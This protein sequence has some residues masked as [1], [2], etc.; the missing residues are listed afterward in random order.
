MEKGKKT[1]VTCGCDV[2]PP[3]SETKETKKTHGP[4]ER[5]R[6]K[7][8]I[9]KPE[10]SQL[11]KTVTPEPVLRLSYDPVD[12]VRSRRQNI[13]LPLKCLDPGRTQLSTVEAKKIISILDETLLRVELI[14][15]FSYVIQNLEEFC[16]IFGPELT[17]ALKEHLRL[18]IFLEAVVSR[19]EKSGLLQKGMARGGIFG[20]ED[21]AGHLPL[22][23][24]GLRGS[25]RNILRLF[26]ANPRAC[27]VVREIAH[28]K[29]ASAPYFMKT[30]L[31]FRAFLFEK[32]LTTPLEEN[33]KSQFLHEMDEQD[34]HNRELIVILE[35]EVSAAIQNR[36]EELSKKDVIVKE[37][38]TQL[39]NLAK[40]SESQI[41][42]TRTEA[43]EQQKEALHSS[44]AKCSKFQQEL[45]QLRAQ[46]SAVIAEDQEVERTLR[47]KKFKVEMEIENW[48]QKYDVDMLERQKEIDDIEVYYSVEK[49]HL[50]ELRE[51]YNLLNQ[52][53]SQIR[54]ERRV[55]QEEKEKA[56]KEMAILV[57]A[58]TLIQALWKG[59]R[60]RSLMRVKRKKKKGKGKKG[61]KK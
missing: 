38:K 10:D 61:P 36:D 37:L 24:H 46:L 11:V 50:A 22:L 21:P 51:K 31:Q 6:P 27:Q 12:V 43:D 52:E 19:L 53:Y 26:D 42:R 34:K 59:Y 29:H 30:L 7:T 41:Q 48:V 14:S 58:A 15:T 20:T 35:E 33:E 16:I 40:C 9:C 39:H 55:K 1:V 13:R 25:V 60:V 4:E 17:G 47:K 45:N 23:V 44:Q 18:C 57:R 2:V 49:E 3:G 8:S 32:L 28:G 54:E 5:Y 56:E